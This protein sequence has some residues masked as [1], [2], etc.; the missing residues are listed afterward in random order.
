MSSHTYTIDI[1]RDG[2]K[3]VQ[4]AGCAPWNTQWP[5]Q[6]HAYPYRISTVVLCFQ[7]GT[8]WRFFFPAP[9]PVL[10]DCNG[11]VVGGEA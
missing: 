6:I 3:V 10:K 9:R 2:G 1:H 8:E 7:L 11:N 4:I 5:D